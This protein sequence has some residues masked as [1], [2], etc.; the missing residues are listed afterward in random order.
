MINYKIKKDADAKHL[1]LKLNGLHKK[2]VEKTS[3]ASNMIKTNS[4][5]D[6]SMYQESMTGYKMMNLPK[7][8]LFKSHMIGN[9]AVAF[10][11]IVE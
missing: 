4:D 7:K 2:E 3:Q 8:E 6:D 9:K 10:S 1:S 11:T 5:Y